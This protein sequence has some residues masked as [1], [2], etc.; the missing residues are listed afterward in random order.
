MLPKIEKPFILDIGIGTGIPAIELA[1]LTNGMIIGI[2]I[3]QTALDKLK[4][5]I[6]RK[7]LSDRI[8]IIYTSIYKTDFPD[9]N[10]NI[11]WDEG[12]LHLLDS[13]KSLK[14]CGRLLKSSG[15]LVMNETIS[16][17]K[18]N[19]FLFPEYGFKLINHFLLPE[20]VWWTNYYSP[21]EKRIKE[22]HWK[23]KNSKDI[24][25]LKQ[26]EREIEMVKKNPKEFD[27]GF[28][29]MQKIK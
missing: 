29:I 7:R 11:L 24:E 27:C 17:F 20:E 10:F 28:Y 8:K 9:E 25:I 12:V 13:K 1:K 2:D 6:E 4:S 14:E 18:N 22:V 3:D 16:W 15:F 19:N 21:L 26:Y 23:Y 5:K